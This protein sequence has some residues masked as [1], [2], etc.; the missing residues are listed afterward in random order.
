MLWIFFTIFV[1]IIPTALMWHIG[2]IDT[3]SITTNITIDSCTSMFLD[4]LITTTFTGIICRYGKTVFGKKQQLISWQ[5]CAQYFIAHVLWTASIAVLVFQTVQIRSIWT[6]IGQCVLLPI[7]QGFTN[8]Q[9]VEKG[10]V[11]EKNTSTQQQPMRLIYVILLLG[12]MLF[13][14]LHMV[15]NI[16]NKCVFHDMSIIALISIIFTAGS[17]YL[18]ITYDV[19]KYVNR[20]ICRTRSCC[21]AIISM[22]SSVYIDFYVVRS[23]ELLFVYYTTMALGPSMYMLFTQT[24]LSITKNSSKNNDIS[25]TPAHWFIFGAIVMVGVVVM[26]L[27]FSESSFAASSSISL[28]YFIIIGVSALIA[29]INQNI[30][31]YQLFPILNG[32]YKQISEWGGNVTK[33]LTMCVVFVMSMSFQKWIVTSL[34]VKQP[35]FTVV[36][37]IFRLISQIIVDYGII[38]TKNPDEVDEL[39]PLLEKMDDIV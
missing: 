26:N 29:D 20:Y 13:A 21:V 14:T 18:V 6:L 39:T 30:V 4:V 22:C 38:H 5:E 27:A 11:C 1:D 34:T 12:S 8:S 16:W 15:V 7:I 24:K 10:D 2:T 25:K 17:D 37:H 19:D 36:M 31:T 3:S 23:D 32:N 28:Y 35:V 33:Y 9:L